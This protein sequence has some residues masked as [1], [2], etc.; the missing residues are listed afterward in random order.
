MLTLDGFTQSHIRINDMRLISL[1]GDFI[2][3]SVYT[4]YRDITGFVS[5]HYL[6]IEAVLMRIFQSVFLLDWYAAK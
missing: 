5:P 4:E 3:L 2:M 1:F 6:Q